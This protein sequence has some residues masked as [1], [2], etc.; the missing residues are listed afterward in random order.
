MLHYRI[1][2]I[3]SFLDLVRSSSHASSP[4]SSNF[5]HH[6]NPTENFSCSQA[7]NEKIDS[8]NRSK[9]KK[10]NYLNQLVLMMMICRY[11]IILFQLL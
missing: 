7:F 4:T 9:L 11:Q 3:F 6:L 8:E 10:G 2:G 5:N 1:L